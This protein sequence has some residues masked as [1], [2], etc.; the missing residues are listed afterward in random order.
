MR[1]PYHV[2]GLTPEAGDEAVRQAYLEMVRRHPPERSP[3]RFREIRAAYESL[4]SERHRLQHLLFTLPEPDLS[5]AW[6]HF[7]RA[8]TP[9]A[10]TRTDFNAMLVAAI[11][12]FRLETD[13]E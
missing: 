9:R 13:Q 8:G 1:D 4:R 12:G 11:E 6:E 3:D 2:L 5:R 7:F 10:F